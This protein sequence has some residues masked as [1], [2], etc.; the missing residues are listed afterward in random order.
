MD[1]VDYYIVMH[2]LIIINTIYLEIVTPTFRDEPFVNL[3]PILIYESTHN[4]CSAWKLVQS[5]L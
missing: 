5:N 1:I 4:Y 3:E 2:S